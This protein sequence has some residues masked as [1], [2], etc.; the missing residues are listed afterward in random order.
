[1]TGVWGLQMGS[2]DYQALLAALE[3]SELIGLSYADLL[4]YLRQDLQLNGATDLLPGSVTDSALA[5]GIKAGWYAS[6]PTALVAATDTVVPLDTPDVVSNGGLMLTGNG[7]VIPVAGCYLAT[8]VVT[9]STAVAGS[10]AVHSTS[11][12]VKYGAQSS[13]AAGADGMGVSALFD[14]NV[15]DVLTLHTTAAAAAST[16]AGS[17]YTYL[18]VVKVA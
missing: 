7:I 16:T 2:M 11:T 17:A 10:V 3:D 1:M 5:P 4:Q 13:P 6:I 15:N 18:G 12:S 9:Y 8:G 14:C